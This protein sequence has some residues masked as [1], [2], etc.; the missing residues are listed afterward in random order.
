M[1][2]GFD[3]MREQRI[4]IIPPLFD[5]ANK[6]RHQIFQIMRLF[7]DQGVDVFC[8]DLPGCN[9]SR[10]PHGEQT[11][12]GWRKAVAAAASHF[13]ATRLVAFRAGSWLAPENLEGWLF[14]PPK[15]QQVLRSLLRAH[16][17]A[18]R[19]AGGA[20]DGGK[21][22]E[23]AKVEGITI[24]GWHLGPQ[25]VAELDCEAPSLSSLH[26]VL[27]QAD[28][29]GTGLW[30]RSENSYDAA[31]AQALVDEVMGEGRNP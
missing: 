22:L 21:M 25:L 4:L 28:I 23:S 13:R 12:A 5:E 8:P 15:P 11:I 6:F 17:L 9:E 10:Q 24:A 18:Q 2:L 26:R 3:Q 29:G 16:G 7:D 20:A 1:V 19:E 31:Q 30:L 27:G 14:A